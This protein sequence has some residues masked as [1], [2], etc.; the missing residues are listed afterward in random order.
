MASI[1]KARQAEMDEARE[2]LREQLRDV[3]VIYTDVTH[4]SRSGMRRAIRA[5]IIRDGRPWDLTYMLAKAG[6]GKVHQTHGGIIMDGCGMDM[7][8]ALV[9]EIGRALIDDRPWSCR[10]DRCPSN[11]HANDRHA[12]RGA[13][14]IHTGDSGYRFR[15]E[16]L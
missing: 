14:V 2:E 10:G 12:P 1:T 6:I 15:K 7:A 3:D 8:F 16:T 9:Y 13:D 11:V 4:V 5:F